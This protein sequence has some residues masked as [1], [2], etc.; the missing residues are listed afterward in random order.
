M[1]E[2]QRQRQRRYKESKRAR[3]EINNEFEDIYKVLDGVLE[4]SNRVYID[5]SILF[6]L[7]K[8]S[9]LRTDC[10]PF[11]LVDL[12]GMNWKFQS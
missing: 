5:G 12:I 6:F 9:F 7:N 8:F 1:K 10:N 11:L 3:E 2:I 4:F